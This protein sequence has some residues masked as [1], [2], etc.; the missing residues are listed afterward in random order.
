MDASET[1]ARE[2]IVAAFRALIRDGLNRGTSGNVSVRWG[3]SF[4]ITPS[5]IPCDVMG[6]GQIVAVDFEGGHSGSLAPSSEWR[7]HRD[8]YRTRL[9]AGA[10]VHVHS[11]HATALACLREDIPAFHYMVAVAGGSDIR[12]ADYATF[13]TADLSQSMLAALDGRTACLL[14]N[15]GQIAFGDTL[16]RALWRAGEVEA[17]A[18]QYTIARSLGRPVLLDEAEM[19]QVLARFATYGKPLE[20]TDRAPELRKR[21]RE[22]QA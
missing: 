13:G 8:I 4:L 22:S 11:P 14:A 1:T 2:A 6:P 12:C 9:D 15:H 17:L 3:G 10:V 20:T 5:G 19:E 16:D 7:L 21:Q 18:Q